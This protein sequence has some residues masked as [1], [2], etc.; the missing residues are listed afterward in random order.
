MPDSAKMNSDH[1]FKKE[2]FMKF[3]NLLVAGL[4]AATTTSAF[5]ANYTIDPDHSSVGFKIKHLAISTVNGQFKN[6]SGNISF[7][8][9]HVADSKA[10]ATIKT[11]SVDTQQAKRDDHLRSPDFFEAAK[12]SEINFKTKK[13]TDA[14]PD[15]F[16]A[17]GDL[18]LHGVTKPVVLDVTVG[19]LGKDPYGNERAA[20][21]ATTK[22]N[23]K[24]FGL[25]WS[26]TLDTGALVVGDDVT[27]NLEI[28]G[29]KQKA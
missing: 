24:D 11:E 9:A 15:S 27:I 19:G 8:P 25:V 4:L 14:T 12:F 1:I 6:F 13:I 2:P 17:E 23:R 5:A 10:E 16:K 20:F 3:K 21:S 26:K 29:I 7:D 18:T 22:I 28:E